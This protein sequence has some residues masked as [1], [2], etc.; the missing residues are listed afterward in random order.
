MKTIL[1]AEDEQFTRWTVSEFLRREHFEVTEAGDGATAIE[2][3]DQRPFDAVIS[4][5]LMPGGLNGLDVLRRYHELSPEKL[6]VLVTGPDG[7]TK[8]EV[9]AIGGIYLEKPVFLEELL[10]ILNSRVMTGE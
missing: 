8:T 7:V 9:E 4:N 1:V 3:I 5:Y 2:F 10:S 6:V